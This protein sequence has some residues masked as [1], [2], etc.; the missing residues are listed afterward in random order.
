MGKSV[1]GG[2]KAKG[3]GWKGKNSV[4]KK[5]RKTTTLEMSKFRL[6]ELC[7]LRIF[8]MRFPFRYKVIMK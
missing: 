5:E 2:M 4:E 7:G 3:C 1:R 8:N 6:E